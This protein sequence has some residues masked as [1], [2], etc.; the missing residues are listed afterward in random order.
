MH[1]KLTVTP[2]PP[3]FSKNKLIYMWQHWAVVQTY[4]ELQIIIISGAKF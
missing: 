2:P 3:N 4:Q 1:G